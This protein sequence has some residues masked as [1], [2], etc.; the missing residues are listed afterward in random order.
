MTYSEFVH[1]VAYYRLHPWGDDWQQA[2]T[3][4]WASVAP[5][6][7]KRMTP[8][9]FMP[10]PPRQKPQSPDYIFGVVKQLAIDAEARR[11]AKGVGTEHQ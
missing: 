11:K 5:H 1:H 7:K 4:A 6:T 2:G 3:M 9:D 10:R 8:R